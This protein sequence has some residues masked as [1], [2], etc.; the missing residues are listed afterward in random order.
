MTVSAAGEVIGYTIT[1]SNT[2]NVTLTGVTLVDDLADVGSVSCPTDVLTVA[3]DAGSVMVCSASYTVTQDDMDAGVDLVNVATGDS[4]QTGEVTD[5]ETVTINQSPLIS[6]VKSS[7]TTELSGPQ[8]VTYD[9]VVSNEGNVT[10]TG[11]SLSDDNDNDDLVCVADTLTVAPDAGS[12]TTCTATH[13]FTQAELDAGGSLDNTV[14][15]SSNEAPDATDDLS[16][17]INQNPALTIV[18]SVDSI[19]STDGVEGT[20]VVDAD[21]DV[22]NYLIEV[23]NAGNVTLTNVAVTDDLVAEGS[24]LPKITLVPGGRR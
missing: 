3:P 2:G 9:Y 13:T 12:R 5:T 8:T 21:G 10:I 22:I 24:G 14:T 6:V 23:T 16:I 1:L 11:L 17:P 20:T 15:A 19:T 4:D 7:V 18:K